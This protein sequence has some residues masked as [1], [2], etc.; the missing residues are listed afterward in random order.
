M[1]LYYGTMKGSLS[2]DYLYVSYRVL[3]SS[4]I[5]YS[6]VE[7]KL[8]C[9]IGITLKLIINLEILWRIFI[10]FTEQWYVNNFVSLESLYFSIAKWT[11][12]AGICPEFSRRFTR[13]S[14]VVCQ[15]DIRLYQDTTFP[16][17]TFPH[18]KGVVQSVERQCHST[19]WR[20]G[21]TY[22]WPG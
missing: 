14:Y 2:T 17:E 18:N 5:Y 6:F 19:G 20:T 12:V 21:W 15:G 7:L 22:D 13:F 8:I 9:L 1:I 10:I 11:L 4:P 16:L 3:C